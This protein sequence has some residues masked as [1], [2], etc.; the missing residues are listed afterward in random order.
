VNLIEQKRF[1]S[2][3]RVHRRQS[4]RLGEGANAIDALV[5][6][7]D[8][9]ELNGAVDVVDAHESCRNRLRQRRLADAWRAGEEKLTKRRRRRQREDVGGE[10]LRLDLM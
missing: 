2:H 9:H 4:R 8:M 6:A 3:A 1:A 10:T 7:V 5:G